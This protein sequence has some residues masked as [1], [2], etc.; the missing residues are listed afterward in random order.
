MFGRKKPD[1]LNFKIAWDMIR[2]A[3]TNRHHGYDL[4]DV[5]KKIALLQ[6]YLLRKGVLK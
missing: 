5:Q 2:D 3:A 1:Q 4:K 6:A